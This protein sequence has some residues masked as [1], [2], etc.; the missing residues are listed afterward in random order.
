[1]LSSHDQTNPLL[2]YITIVVLHYTHHM[3]MA[4]LVSEGGGAVKMLKTFYYI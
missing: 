1:M 4:R 2:A 3:N